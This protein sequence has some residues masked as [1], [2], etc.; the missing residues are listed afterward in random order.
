MSTYPSVIEGI[1]L[2]FVNEDQ[3]LSSAHTQRQLWVHLSCSPVSTL[4]LTEAINQK[5]DWHIQQE[6]YILV[7]YMFNSMNMCV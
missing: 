3:I 1:S 5:K 4:A 7:V 2:W 6:V